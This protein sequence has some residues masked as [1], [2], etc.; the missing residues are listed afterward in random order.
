MNF[1]RVVLVSFFFLVIF[2]NLEA[3]EENIKEKNSKISQ[4]FVEKVF[5]DKDFQKKFKKVSFEYSSEELSRM[6]LPD[7]DVQ[8]RFKVIFNRYDIN[9]EISYNWHNDGLRIIV[10][11]KIIHYIINDDELDGEVDFGL[12][13]KF[14]FTKKAK[15]FSKIDYEIE[16]LDYCSKFQPY[17]QKR[18]NQILLVIKE[19]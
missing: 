10:N 6:K 9:F 18:Y 16:G 15:R 17:Y 4:T 8:K 2:V 7:P 1:F 11:S 13:D 14:I 12:I 19:F 3:R 5:S